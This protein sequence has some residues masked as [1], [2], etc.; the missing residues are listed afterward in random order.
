MVKC[1]VESVLRSFIWLNLDVSLTVKHY[2]WQREWSDMKTFLFEGKLWWQITNFAELSHLIVEKIARQCGDKM[3]AMAKAILILCWWLWDHSSH[4]KNGVTFTLCRNGSPRNLWDPN[5]S[6]CTWTGRREHNTRLHFE[7][8]MHALHH[9]LM[10][11]LSD[12]FFA[13]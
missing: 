3:V 8:P 2:N 10:Y 6:R 9:N 7:H 5:G 1:W 13:K 4:S 12:T 11:H